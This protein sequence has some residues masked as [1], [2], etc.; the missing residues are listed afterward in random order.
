MYDEVKQPKD[1][2]KI[3]KVTG[4]VVG[5][6]ALLV[7]VLCFVFKGKEEER[8]SIEYLNY[9]ESDLDGLSQ[10]VSWYDVAPDFEVK[11][12]TITDSIIYAKP[13]IGAEQL[14]IIKTGEKLVVVAQCFSDDKAIGWLRIDY[15]GGVGYIN[16]FDIEYIY[17]MEEVTE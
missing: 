2:K 1:W 16:S 4:I 11:V 8:E 15:N 6:L 10:E 9:G 14:G 5:L 3:L 17:Q 12:E 7:G 13:S